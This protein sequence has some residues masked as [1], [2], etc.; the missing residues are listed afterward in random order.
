RPLAETF[1]E[2]LLQWEIMRSEAGE[3][4]LLRNGLRPPSSDLSKGN[5]IFRRLCAGSMDDSTSSSLSLSS[6]EKR[7]IRESFCECL[8]R[9]FACQG[10]SSVEERQE[11]LLL[12]NWFAPAGSTRGIKLRV[13]RCSPV[14]KNA[15]SAPAFTRKRQRSQ[16][17]P[18]E[19]SLAF[20]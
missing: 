17:R 10:R 13:R 6:P 12:I 2:Q 9:V 18:C 1:R 19:R 4:E 20:A 5:Q 14:L 11:C 16:T 7:L 15:A 8:L 3:T